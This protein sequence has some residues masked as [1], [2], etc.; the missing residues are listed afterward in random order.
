MAAANPTLPIF[1]FTGQG[2]VKT[3][4]T[5]ERYLDPHAVDIKLI[6]SGDRLPPAKEQ[7]VVVFPHGNPFDMGKALS[8]TIGKIRDYLHHSNRC[9]A[10]GAGSLMACGNLYVKQI[11]G[12]IRAK[13]A[14]D[15][16]ACNLFQG[17]AIFPI[18]GV[19]LA[20]ETHLEDEAPRIL[21]NA[22]DQKR[23]IRFFNNRGVGFDAID[24]KNT[25]VIA[26]YVD[27]RAECVLDGKLIVIDRPAAAIAF[28]T[29]VLV[30]MQPDV[31][32]YELLPFANHAATAHHGRV[33]QQLAQCNHERTLFMREILSCLK[34]P[35]KP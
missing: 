28:D 32:D 14:P 33:V 23:E 2:A 11:A 27:D 18:H 12:S 29:T 16:V 30:G 4:Q 10:F 24:Q 35:L 34:L 21:W 20:N 25:T 9:L 26:E 7:G 15:W 17:A 13:H 1:I 22:S 8:D 6:D 19:M 3:Q 5:L 31:D